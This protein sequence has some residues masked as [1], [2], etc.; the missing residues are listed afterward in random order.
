LEGKRHLCQRRDTFGI[1]K[2]TIEIIET[3]LKEKRHLCWSTDT[4]GGTEIPFGEK[5][6]P[7]S[8]K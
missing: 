8:E 3:L 5:E 1:K 2:D 4:F 6:T 7:V